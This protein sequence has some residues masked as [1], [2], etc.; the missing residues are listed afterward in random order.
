MPGIARLASESGGRVTSNTNDMT[1]AYAPARRDLGCRYTIGFYDEKPEEDEEHKVRV[2]VV[3]TGL[4]VIHS[5]SYAF[6]SPAK[7]RERSLSA[8]W[9][10]PGFFG[11]GEVLAHVFPIRPKGFKAWDTLIALDFPVI[12]NDSSTREF[13]AILMRGSTEVRNISR[14]VTL[15]IKTPNER[16]PRVSFLETAELKPGDYTLKTVVYDPSTGNPSSTEIKINVPKVVEDAPFIVGPIL[17]RRAAQDVVIRAENTTRRKSSDPTQDRIGTKDS[18][19]PYLVQELS[20]NEPAVA[21]SQVCTLDTKKTPDV[22]IRRS[23]TTDEGISSGMLDPIPFH[24]EGDGRVQCQTFLDILPVNSMKPGSYRF[25]TALVTPSTNTTATSSEI[26][27]LV[28]P[29][30]P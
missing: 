19:R 5:A 12:V 28:L 27:F 24:P 25:Q 17:G 14:K 30:E 29:I 1:I 23:L 7:R 3:R 26:R 16:K 21:L 11:G 22:Q 20:K 9:L 6:T 2:D 4:R 10:A 8:A 15:N 18:F 13:G